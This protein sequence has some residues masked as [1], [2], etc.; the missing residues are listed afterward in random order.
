VPKTGGSFPILQPKDGSGGQSTKEPN[1]SA[2][3]LTLDGDH[4]VIAGDHRIKKKQ[5]VVI[6]AGLAGAAVLL[7]YIL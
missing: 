1:S 6:G 4:I 3:F 5:A 7:K 2:S